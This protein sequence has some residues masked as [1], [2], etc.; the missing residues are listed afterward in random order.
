LSD[1]IRLLVVDDIAETRDHI[2]KLISFEP[3][4]ELVG[5]AAGGLEALDVAARVQPDVV[6]M[7]VNMPGMDGIETSERLARNVPGAAVVMMSVQNEAEY[8]RR[9]MLAGAREFLVK[10][11]TSD[12]LF[13]SVRQVNVRQRESRL[14]RVPVGPGIT[15]DGVGRPERRGRVVAV[16]SAKG[17]VGRT[18][19]AANLAIAAAT[20]LHQTVA[21]V[22]ANFQFG[23][24]GL[25][26]NVHPTASATIADV[27]AEL[28]EG[29][30]DAVDPALIAHSSGVKVLLPPPSPEMAELITA[31]HMRRILARLRQ[32]HELVVV[33][34]FSQLHDP[35]LTILDASDVV[36]TVLTFDLTSIK[37]TRVFLGVAE[38]LGYTEDKIRIVLNKADSAHGITLADVERSI[39]RKVD[40]TIG[41]DA[42]TTTHA[43]NNGQPFA[44]ASGNSQISRDITAIA[45]A[46]AA[47][48]TAGVAD[49]SAPPPPARVS[50]QAIFA[51]R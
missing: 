45:R 12:E 46:V 3:D 30:V 51:R 11:F 47:P 50:R 33:D 7:D 6:L 41:S 15:A 31:D 21:L 42:R 19:L 9:S 17:G 20:D 18:T 8:L 10:P 49:V 38:R 32:R 39:G 4:I 16:F 29:H 35:T 28:A 36:L 2:A 13:G 25:L 26:L 14:Q 1:S 48:V 40:Y 27:L 44:A 43:L 34:C 22:D 5:T 24:I 37:N 23:D